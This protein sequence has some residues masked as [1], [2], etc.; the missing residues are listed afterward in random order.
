MAKKRLFVLSL[1]LMVG[2]LVGGGLLPLRKGFAQNPVPVAT[3]APVD[4]NFIVLLSDLHLCGSEEVPEKYQGDDV[5]ATEM[6]DRIL[7][8]NPRP[9]AVLIFGDLASK[10]GDEVDYVLAKSLLSRLDEA[11]IPWRVAMGNHDNRSAFLKVFPEQATLSELP[12]RH[13]FRFKTDRV[14]FLLLDILDDNDAPVRPLDDLQRNWLAE[15][16]QEA[17]KDGRP[18]L[19]CS[20]Y[21][22]ELLVIDDILRDAPAVVGCLQAHLHLWRTDDLDVTPEDGSEKVTIPR[23]GIPS[24]AYGNSVGYLP[25]YLGDHVWAFT[26]E[27]TQPDP[28]SGATYGIKR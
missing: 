24:V 5:R 18:V 7:A 21:P 10:S 14:D 15:R 16:L 26:F 12:N 17:E 23:V 2:V 4:P 22:M 28:N 20:H 6:I 9:A 19:V 1:F 27:A 3:S 13:T 11:G 25:L 8:M